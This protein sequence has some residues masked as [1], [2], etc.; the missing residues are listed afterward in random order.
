MKCSWVCLSST[1]EMLPRTSG[2]AAL[3]WQTALFVPHCSVP[4]GIAAS[5]SGNKLTFCHSKCCKA[6]GVGCQKT[7]NG[8]VAFFFVK[9]IPL[10]S[11][12]RGP[13]CKLRTGFFF[14]SFYSP[15]GLKSKGK[16]EGSVT[17]TGRTEK[18]KLVRSLLHLY[19][20]CAGFRNDFLS[21]GTS[22]NF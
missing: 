9:F 7:L 13:H 22:S 10:T 18:S 6:S 19:C 14:P 1:T 11:P 16:S 2:S 17:Y 20:V 8:S 4:Q 5:F 15:V 3:S 21:R 12:V